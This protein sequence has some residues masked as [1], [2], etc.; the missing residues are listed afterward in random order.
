M[1]VLK[2]FDGTLRTRRV[3]HCGTP[4]SA[5]NLLP[6]TT[7]A[8]TSTSL[9]GDARAETDT[10]LY[11][12]QRK[13]PPTEIVDTLARFVWKTPSDDGI[14]RPMEPA[15]LATVVRTTAFPWRRRSSPLHSPVRRSADSNRSKTTL[16]NGARIH[17]I[18]FLG[19]GVTK[20]ICENFAQ[21]PRVLH[22]SRL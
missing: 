20:E 7:A 6:N 5:R 22:A 17:R 4:H 11:L 21:T 9:D 13:V 10:V 14:V 18:N 19:G 15:F 3:P 12:S 16:A 2:H 8:L 1:S